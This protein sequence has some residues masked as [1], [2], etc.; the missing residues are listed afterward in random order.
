VLK[1]FW[2][3]KNIKGYIRKKKGE[4]GET[5]HNRGEGGR[6]KR[7]QEREEEGEGRQLLTHP[8]IAW[9]RNEQTKNKNKN[10]NNRDKKRKILNKQTNKTWTA[11][12]AYVIHKKEHWHKKFDF[13]GITMGTCNNHSLRHWASVRLSTYTLEGKMGGN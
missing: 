3:I 1:V 5:V 12:K 6:G 7:T 4:M 9:L 10:N 13:E 8:R 2:K 11:I